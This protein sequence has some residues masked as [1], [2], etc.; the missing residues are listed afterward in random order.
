MITICAIIKDCY[1]DYLIEWI[2]YHR[3]IGVDKFI[4]YDNE[5]ETPIKD[6]LSEYSNIV[7]INNINGLNMQIKAYN[8]CIE[9]NK[10][11]FDWIIFIDDDEFI[12][13][14]DIRVFLNKNNDFDCIKLKWKTFGSNSYK[15]KPEN[16]LLKSFIKRL[17]D[18]NPFNNQVKLIVKP[19]QI[20][21]F[22]S[23]HECRFKNNNVKILKDLNNIYIN[24]YFLKSEEEFKRKLK[25][26]RADNV[27]LAY[28]Q[29]MFSEIDK[30]CIIED[31]IILNIV[32]EKF[33]KFKE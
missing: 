33:N 13:C 4:I 17:P 14:K 9:N 2:D 5:S 12:V 27:K 16:G 1:S 23:P 10:N 29:N 3:N 21:E 20:S 25:R 18:N 8:H 24:H 32:N 30:D 31:L 19:N 15:I 7:I 11:D 6:V 28:S 26:G 22:I